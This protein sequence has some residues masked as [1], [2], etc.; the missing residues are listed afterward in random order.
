YPGPPDAEFRRRDAILTSH[1]AAI[2]RDPATITRSMQAIVRA[3]QPDAAAATRAI[4][5]DMIDAGVRHI[6]LAAV[7]D[8]RPFEWLVD[9]I[10]EPVRAKAGSS[11]PERARVP[12]AAG[13]GR[14]ARTPTRRNP[15]F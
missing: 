15:S 13:T 12:A 11:A 3:T 8:G 1:C 2:G 6:V 5:L 10:V 14:P 9:E 7:L 4:L